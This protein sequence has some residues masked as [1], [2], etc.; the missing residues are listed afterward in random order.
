MTVLPTGSDRAMLVTFSGPGPASAY[1]RRARGRCRPL[2]KCSAGSPSADRT[3]RNQVHVLDNRDAL[4]RSLQALELA[5]AT[6][7]KAG[8]HICRS[9]KLPGKMDI[10]LYLASSA[11]PYVLSLLA[12]PGD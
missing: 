4:V 7:T 1:R 8:S 12:T 9:S 6:L 5:S 10:P 2:G 3:N 11:Q